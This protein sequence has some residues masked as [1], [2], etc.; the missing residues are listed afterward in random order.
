MLRL[1]QEWVDQIL[2]QPESGMDYHILTIT[3]VDGRHFEQCVFISGHITQ[4]RG[5]SAIP[6]AAEQISA[7]AVTHDRWDFNTGR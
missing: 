7:V 4:V 6:F 1:P 5:H 3:L 2:P